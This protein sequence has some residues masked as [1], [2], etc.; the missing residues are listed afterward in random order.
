M[1]D[2]MEMWT[3]AS[4]SIASLINLPGMGCV[5]DQ[6]D[7]I[8]STSQSLPVDGVE[9]FRKTQGVSF[10]LRHY[11][12]PRTLLPQLLGCGHSSV[13]GLFVSPNKIIHLLCTF[14]YKF[15]DCRAM[16]LEDGFPSQASGGSFS[17]PCPID[18]C[19]LRHHFNHDLLLS[20]GDGFS[21]IT[22]F[23]PKHTVCM[24]TIRPQQWN[25][26]P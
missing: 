25:V 5:G 1:T 21:V 26:G 7:L 23:K 8:I 15:P 11:P 24:F 22:S 12:V 2:N 6:C 10:W 9:G 20:R 18:L 3:C 13:F 4:F 16:D 19:Q 14:Q 17:V